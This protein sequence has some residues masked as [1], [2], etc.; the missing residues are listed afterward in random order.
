MSVFTGNGLACVRGERSVFAGLDFRIEDGGA[1][2]LTGPNGSGKSSLLRLMAGLNRA[3]AGNLA[4]DGVDVGED[5]QA[6]HARLHYV[7]H[8]DAVKPV[9]SVFEQLRFWVEVRGGGDRRA[10]ARV[11]AALIAFGIERLADVPGRFLSAG[12]RRRVNLARI[13]VAPAPLWLLDEPRTALDAE[14]VRRL[15]AAI[16]AHRAEGGLVAM[17]MHGGHPPPGAAVLDLSRFQRLA[18]AAGDWGAW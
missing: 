1:V 3:A 7:G 11:E 15:D 9:L 10:L 16:A 12:Q 4:W 13:L 14:A 5:P 2:V 18:D 17:A 6:H 8:L